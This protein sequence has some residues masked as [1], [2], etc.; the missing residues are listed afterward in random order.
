MLLLVVQLTSGCGEGGAVGWVGQV[1]VVG[2]GGVGHMSAPARY[3]EAGRQAG[4]ASPRTVTHTATPHAPVAV[5]RFMAL[6]PVYFLDLFTSLVVHH[7]LGNSWGLWCVWSGRPLFQVFANDRRG[8]LATTA[9]HS[10]PPPTHLHYL[11]LLL[12]LTP[13]Q[14]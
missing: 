8:W 3:H 1:R 10:P 9:G 6:H 13:L 7:F 5:S 4:Q 2:G 12:L 11:L 14:N